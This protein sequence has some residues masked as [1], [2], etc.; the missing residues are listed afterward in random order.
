MVAAADS[1][2]LVQM[3]VETVDA[4]GSGEREAG[5]GGGRVEEG[6]GG[7]TVAEQERVG[8]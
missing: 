8:W 6:E 7:T 3:A 4:A 2:N 5:F 1:T